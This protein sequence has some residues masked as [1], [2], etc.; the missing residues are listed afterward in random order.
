VA[1]PQHSMFYGCTEISGYLLA[2]AGRTSS[3]MLRSV[4]GTRRPRGRE[5]Q[6]RAPENQARDP[7][8]SGC[9]HR[10]SA[11]SS[12]DREQSLEEFPIALQSKTEV[13]RRGFF[14]AGPLRLEP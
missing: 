2:S 8:M 14:A 9:S 4:M 6:M 10:S 5:P 13:F 1:R 3:V 7:A 11:G 12:S